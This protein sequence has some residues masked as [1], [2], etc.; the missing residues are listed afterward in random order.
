[1]QHVRNN[2]SA[3][4]PSRTYFKRVTAVGFTVYH[5]HDILAHGLTR[6]VAITPVVCGTDAILANVEILRIIYVFEGASLY[7]VD[8]AG[9]QVDED[10]PRDVPRVVTLVE[11]DVFPVTALGR[12]ILEVSVLANSVFLTKLLP[13]LAANWELSA[14]IGAECPWCRRPDSVVN[15]DE[16]LTAVAALACLNRDDLPPRS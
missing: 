10:S 2:I 8:D 11:E 3:R 12:E 14:T 16:L 5:L 13:E 15:M 6:L 1:M 4:F 7:S 9:F